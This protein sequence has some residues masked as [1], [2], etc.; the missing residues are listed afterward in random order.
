MQS[1]PPLKLKAISSGLEAKQFKSGI[2]RVGEMG[3]VYLL[4]HV[5]CLVERLE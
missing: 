3:A 2:S 5:Q 4:E 1:L